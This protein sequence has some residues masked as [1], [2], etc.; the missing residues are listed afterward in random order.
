MKIEF[1]KGIT[2]TPFRATT[3]RAIPLH[4]EAKAK[5]LIKLNGNMS[6]LLTNW[7][8]NC[9]PG[10]AE[11]P[12]AKVSLDVRIAADAAREKPLL[13]FEEWKLISTT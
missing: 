8:G 13:F 5:E 12:L 3:A 11:I 1:K 4:K 6:S 7:A 10:K 2:A 9:H